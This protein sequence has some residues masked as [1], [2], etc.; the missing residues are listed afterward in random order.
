[1]VDAVAAVSLLELL[2]A[3]V[4]LGIA[5]LAW[6]YRR[7]PAGTPLFVLVV[8]ASV[9]ALTAGL[10]SLVTAPGPT[11]A[12]QSLGYL[13]AGAVAVAWFY[14][15]VEHAGLDRWERPPVLA[16]FSLLLVAEAATLATN[17]VHHL[18]M[19]EASRVTAGGLIDPVPGP[20]LWVNAAWKMGLVLAGTGYLSLRAGHEHG[21]VRSQSLA[22][23]ASGLLPLAAVL[24]ELLDLLAVPGLDIGVVGIGVGFTVLLWALF[25]A[26]FL[27]V[28]PIARETLMENMDDAVVA[29]DTAGRVV[30]LNP[31]ARALFDVGGEV[32]G[33]PAAAL[34]DGVPRLRDAIDS[35]APDPV[36][37]E[38]EVGGER[39]YYELVV[40]PVTAGD[41]PATAGID[42]E[43]TVLG[44]L[45]VFHDVTDRRRRER[46]LEAQNERLE[47]FASILSHDLRN[48]LNVAMAELEMA[49]AA[50]ANEHH[51]EIGRALDR[52]ESMI[53][54]VLALA[55]QRET[56][57]SA[58]PVDLG[59]VLGDCW[60]SIETGDA[61][62][63]R[64]TEQVIRADGG[65]LRQLLE[66]LLANAVD[67]GG[68]AVAVTVGD[69]DDG[70]YVADDG[71]GIPPDRREEV[72]ERGYSTDRDG[73]GFGLA[74][75]TAAVEAHDWEI[76]VTESDAGG[77]R[78]EVTNVE[79][80]QRRPDDATVR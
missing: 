25:Y 71:P 14:V 29:L 15:V 68:P 26:D 11:V 62:L 48:P 5:S 43:D 21:V 79:V 19:A 38:M 58:D 73:T 39:R 57:P 16:A 20:L 70:F 80:L 53:G 17:P 12:A 27:E 72:F 41:G 36:E 7:R 32:V 37:F 61:R 23:V 6:G 45:L 63:E 13:S 55:R 4:A 76:E 18:Y 69:L 51:E 52:M 28:A 35:P 10:A 75:V 9:W 66:N 77:A 47:E 49:R 46:T 54:D 56:V 60:C 33:R 74:I 65:R 42:P 67:H 50:G 30:D 1:M 24:V 64:E 3:A 59:A 40:S 8:A 22:V 44:R 34:F 2:V 31:R 78:F